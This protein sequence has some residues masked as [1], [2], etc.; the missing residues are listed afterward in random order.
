MPRV[1]A[2]EEEGLSSMRPVKA[3]Q[4]HVTKKRQPGSESCGEEELAV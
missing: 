1:W 2:S 4:V 3:A